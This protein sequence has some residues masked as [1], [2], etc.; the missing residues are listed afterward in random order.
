MSYLVGMEIASWVSQLRKG[1]AELAV[2]AALDT[3]D[4]YGLELLEIINRHESLI[5]EGAVYPLLSR[6]EKEGKVTSRW[7]LEDSA[8]PRKYYRLTSEG[9]AALGAMRSAWTHFRK[10]MSA[11]VETS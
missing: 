11:L 4:L 8:H 10:A 3:Q 9:R 1:A 2:V 6:L 7:E 5:S